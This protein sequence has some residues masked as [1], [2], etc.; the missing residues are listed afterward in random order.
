MDSDFPLLHLA[1]QALLQ[2]LPP[3]AVSIVAV[4][5]L[6]TRRG[7]LLAT[8][9]FS[10]LGALTLLNPLLYGVIGRLGAPT[11]SLVSIY[12]IVGVFSSIAHCAALVL[13]LLGLLK[14]LPRPPR[15]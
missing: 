9:G 2:Y 5:L 3:L 8:I 1:I 4:V 7:P 6:A 11:S 15:P 12:Q 10:L 14:L 13:I